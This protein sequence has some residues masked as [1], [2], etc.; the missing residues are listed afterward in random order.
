NG[1]AASTTELRDL[2]EQTPAPEDRRKMAGVDGSEKSV[3]KGVR[4]HKKWSTSAGE[5]KP[6]RVKMKQENRPRN[7]NEPA[8]GFSGTRNKATARRS[9]GE[10]PA[11]GRNVNIGMVA[12]PGTMTTLMA[13]GLGALPL[14]LTTVS[15]SRD[16]KG[17]KNKK[18]GKLGDG[19]KDEE[20]GKWDSSS[21]NTVT[22]SR[23]RV[24]T[25]AA[26]MAL[27]VLLTSLLAAFCFLLA[28]GSPQK[29]FGGR[30]ASS[31][32]E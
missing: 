7:S 16:P 12:V 19:D 14:Q 2:T 30:A 22:L 18:T 26:Y 8:A 5:T 3:K 4:T 17:P 13:A 32:N 11:Y 1:Q 10:L 6:V 23:S 25:T 29:G 31:A 28:V 20:S 9:K 21:E 24:N 27:A 15:G